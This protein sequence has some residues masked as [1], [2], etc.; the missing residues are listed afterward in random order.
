VSREQLDRWCE[1][2]ILSLVL[3]ILVL[4]PV[5]MGGAPAVAFIGLQVL[6]GLTVALWI[7][8]LWL[9][10]RPQLLWPPMCWAVIAFVL[11]A[12][13]RYFTAD[14]EYVA[15]KELLRILV[16][17]FLFFIV[18]NY[19][20][21]QERVQ[22][23]TLTL[24]GLAMVISWYAIYQFLASSDKVWW[25][26]SPYKHRGAG[27][28]F[29]PN[30]LAGF[31]EMLLPLALTFTLA[32]RLKPVTRVFVGYSALVILAGIAVTVSRGGW[33]ATTLALVALFGVLSFRKGHR[34]ASLVFFAVIVG[35]V[36]VI[37]P[38][39][40]FFKSR[41]NQM[42]AGEKFDDDAR[43]ITWRPALEIWGENLWWGAGPG[44]FDERFRAFRPEGLQ[45]QPYRAHNDFLNTLTD[46]GVAGAVIVAT[47]LGLLVVGIIKTWRV[48]R[49]PRQ[50]LG[51]RSESNRFAFVLGASVGLL[52]LFFH[53]A[54]DFNMHIP[55]NA[56][57]AITLMALLVSHLRFTTEAYWVK[58]RPWMSS[59]MTLVLVA[60]G[61]FF[62]GEG[63]RGASEQVWLLRA[64]AAEPFSTD[65]ISLLKRAYAVEPRNPQTPYRIGE[66]L[67]RQSQEGS[68]AYSDAEGDYRTRADEA[69]EWFQRSLKLNQWNGYA[70][71]GCGLC[72]DWLGRFEESEPYFARAE[73]LDPK[74]YYMMEYIGLH[75]IELGNYAAARAWFER[76]IRLDWQNPVGRNYL[77][78]CN[79][80]LQEAATNDL[81]ARLKQ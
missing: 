45:Q 75:W 54:V 69:I 66:A 80:R 20:H 5:A 24:L 68:F 72:L 14:I 22:L 25:F 78:I 36:L 38:K 10:P 57:L 1:L 29:C 52:A 27:T 60:G 7:A 41:V 74:G 58:L 11:Y 50:A 9:S 53:S 3:G 73:E 56:I 48:V 19:L 42:V 44:L 33:V 39:S 23:I 63:V 8:R 28:Y 21:R 61:G 67:W 77:H 47:A 26:V 17:G 18:L 37:G 49:G 4:G 13:A 62:I 16:Y 6:T 12:I 51:G 76:S 79:T 81:R 59:V 43:L 46:W 35:G 65:Q 40:H 64:A 15:R 2:S 55:A 32:S 71:L 70:Y 30:H 34:L 31:L